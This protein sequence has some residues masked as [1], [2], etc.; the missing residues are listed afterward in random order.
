MSSRV[1]GFRRKPA[2]RQHGHEA[3]GLQLEQRLAQGGAADP[4][5]Q[6]DGVQVQEGAGLQ[7]A[8]VHLVAEVLVDLFPQGAGLEGGGAGRVAGI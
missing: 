3:L 5:A 1:R 2:A 4:Q 7:L 6:G 8:V